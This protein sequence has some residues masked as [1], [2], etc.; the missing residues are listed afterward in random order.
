[1]AWQAAFSD[2]FMVLLIAIGGIAGM[3]LLMALRNFRR[4]D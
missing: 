1:M 2:G 3:L 4:C